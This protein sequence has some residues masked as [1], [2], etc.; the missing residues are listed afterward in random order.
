M[1]LD[2]LVIGIDFS[3]HSVEAASW[4]ARHFAPGAELVL[5]HVISIPEAPPIVRS[6]FPRR[7]LLIE[8]VREGAEK[9]LRELSLSLNAGRVWLEIR[10]GKIVESLTEVATEFGGHH[11]RRRAR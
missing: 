4:A 10:E 3:T 2:K 8:T 9:R 7:D 1:K 6:R 5:V 11:R